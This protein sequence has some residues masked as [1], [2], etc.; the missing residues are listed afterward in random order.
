MEINFIFKKILHL[1]P[2]SPQHC[3]V[4]RF[5]NY[6]MKGATHAS[7]AAFWRVAVDA[8]VRISSAVATD[9]ILES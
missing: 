5:E 9:V 2:T 7:R 3:V 6:W 8:I 4:I 1:T